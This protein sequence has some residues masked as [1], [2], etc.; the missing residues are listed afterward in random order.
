MSESK[1]NKSIPSG[2]GPDV[3]R[4]IKRLGPKAFYSEHEDTARNGT[5]GLVEKLKKIDPGK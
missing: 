2:W 4:A 3:G 1:E 5:R